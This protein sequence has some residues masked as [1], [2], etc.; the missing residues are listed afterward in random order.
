MSYKIAIAS[1][2]GKVID[3]TFG[4]AQEFIIYEVGMGVDSDKGDFKGEMESV[5]PDKRIAVLEKRL[6]RQETEDVGET[7]SPKCNNSAENCGDG[8]GGSEDGGNCGSG[9]GCGGS[10]AVSAKVELI[11][12]CRCV[13][14]KKIGFPIQKQL[15]R[16][17]ISFFDV[18]CTV[19]EALNKISQYFSRM[20]KH[21]SL[22]GIR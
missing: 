13:V 4:S 14:C 15:E 18:D 6:F 16:K 8:C 5:K 22:R 1:S 17:A 12:D 7:S 11:S 9:G 10:Q 3:E 2:D 19:E 20:D 21:E